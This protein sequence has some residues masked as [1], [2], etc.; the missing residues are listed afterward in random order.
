MKL[1]DDLLQITTRL[2]L[3]RERRET[4]NVAQELT[5]LV[6]KV[7]KLESAKD[8][9]K[10]KSISATLKFN[11]QEISKKNL[12]QTDLRHTL[13]NAPA[14]NAGFIMKFVTVE[15]VMICMVQQQTLQRQKRDFFNK[16]N[17]ER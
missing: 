8:Y 7:D 17:P 2:M 1:S 3:A 12:L 10:E 16:P 9:Q 4:L 5:A 6:E 14:E 13:L 11:R 15:T